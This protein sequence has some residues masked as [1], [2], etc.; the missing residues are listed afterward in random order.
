LEDGDGDEECVQDQEEQDGGNLSSKT[1]S[2]TSP[3]ESNTLSSPF[4]LSPDQ[5][6]S[7][8]TLTTAAPA[9]ATAT[10]ASLSAKRTRS[11]T[12]VP[13]SRNNPNSNSNSDP[14]G[15]RRTRSGTLVG[16]L[17]LPSTASGSG[18]QLVVG[19]GNPS[20][21]RTRERS[22]TILAGPSPSPVGVGAR[23]T[24]SGTVIGRAPPPPPP[25]PVSASVSL[26]ILVSGGRS[27]RQTELGAEILEEDMP[28]T[29]S[30]RS[31]NP[32]NI[33]PVEYLV[34]DALDE[35]NNSDVDIDV[36]PHVDALY[37]P[38]QSAS[39]DPIDFLRLAN[40]QDYDGMREKHRSRFGFG[41][42]IEKQENEDPDVSGGGAEKGM[43][44]EMAWCIADEPPSPVLPKNENKLMMGRRNI[45]GE[46]LSVRGG[47]GGVRSGVRGTANGKGRRGKGM[48]GKG[49]TGRTR[50]RFV[51]DGHEERPDEIVVE[52]EE[53]EDSDD[54]LLLRDG[55]TLGVKNRWFG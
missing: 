27:T 35:F 33:D 28:T 2:S 55:S 21:R 24:R 40:F 48:K 8:A 49:E 3:S 39:P 26:P 45:K 30:P 38:R 43:G 29:S 22:G 9:T 7:A 1:L 10:A 15:T 34:D 54:E 11:G 46:I 20:L 47:H 17:P 25:I 13:S 19:N 31:S 44:D 16:P 4:G 52:R 53:G 41:L 42:T 36:E 14:P 51:I 37:M 50:T 23:R 5:L 18:V 6:Q 12:I 32:G